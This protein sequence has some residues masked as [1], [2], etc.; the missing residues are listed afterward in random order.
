[1]ANQYREEERRGVTKSSFMKDLDINPT[2][3]CKS[4]IGFLNHFVGPLYKLINEF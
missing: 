4:Q 2:A 3:A 1:M